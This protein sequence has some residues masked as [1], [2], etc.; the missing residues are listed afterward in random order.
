MFGGGKVKDADKFTLEHFRRGAARRRRWPRKRNAASRVSR[1]FTV[2][3]L[4]RGA[5]QA[6]HRDGW[7]QSASRGCPCTRLR[8]CAWPRL[9]GSLRCALP[10]SALQDVLVETFRAMAELLTWGDQHEPAIFEFF[11]ENRVCNALRCA[12]FALASA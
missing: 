4:E 6:R 1:A 8:R 3:E 9:W 11:V 7:Q 10:E 5:G 12:C 2:Q